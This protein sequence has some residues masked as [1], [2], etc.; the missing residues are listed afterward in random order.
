M[1][2]R[3]GKGSQRIL[4]DRSK[5]LER[6]MYHHSDKLP[7]IHLK[8]ILYLEKVYQEYAEKKEET[9]ENI[10]GHLRLGYF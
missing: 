8:L 5:H 7:S 3:I 9:V 4:L 2:Y 6:Y 1:Y 10:S